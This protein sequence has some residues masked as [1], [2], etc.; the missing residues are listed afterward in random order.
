MDANK[1]GFVLFLVSI[2]EQLRELYKE[3]EWPYFFFYP[4]MQN[5]LL[6]LKCE[7]ETSDKR[8]W[9]NWHKPFSISIQSGVDIEKEAR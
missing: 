9:L 2:L 4:Y 6:E 7:M 5:L 8:L 3:M 1:S